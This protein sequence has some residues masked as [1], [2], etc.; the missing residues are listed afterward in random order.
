MI[1]LKKF[2]ILLLKMNK[3]NLYDK[4]AAASFA[5]YCIETKNTN[6]LHGNILT[7]I[8]RENIKNVLE[9]LLDEY[10]NKKTINNYLNNFP[11]ETHEFIKAF[12]LK[13][14]IRI[15]CDSQHIKYNDDQWISI[16]EAAELAFD[17]DL[18]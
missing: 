13:E 1:R 18:A 9:N 4:I 6:M 17:W 14:D 15:Y 2:I 12:V 10:E 11:E 3:V 5:V 16:R 7:Y 8:K